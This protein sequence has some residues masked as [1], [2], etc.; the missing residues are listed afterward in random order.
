MSFEKDVRNVINERMQNDLICKIITYNDDR[1]VT[2]ISWL[3][4][5]LFLE[6]AFGGNMHHCTGENSYKPV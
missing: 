2:H 3:V 6:I 5:L 1:I 4:V